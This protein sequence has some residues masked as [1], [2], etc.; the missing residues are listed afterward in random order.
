MLSF[1]R[2][3]HGF[4]GHDC[5][6]SKLGAQQCRDPRQSGCENTAKVSRVQR[7]RGNLTVTSPT[8][9]MCASYLSDAVMSEGDYG[10]Q[11]QV[12]AYFSTFLYVWKESST[13]GGGAFECAASQWCAWNN[14]CWH[15]HPVGPICNPKPQAPLSPSDQI[16]VQIPDVTTWSWMTGGQGVF[17]YINYRAT[18]GW[19]RCD[20]S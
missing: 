10:L 17:N 9:N 18:L 8:V 13:K 11:E 19:V 4:A 12:F 7:Y 2:Q 20:F 3:N 1:L 6:W 16:W 5:R 14:W 15:I